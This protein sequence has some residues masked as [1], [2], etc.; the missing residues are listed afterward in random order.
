MS[1]VHGGT[2]PRRL[3]GLGAIATSLAGWSFFHGDTGLSGVARAADPQPTIFDENWQ[4]PVVR[5]VTPVYFYQETTPPPEVA[6]G[7]T[8]PA[9]MTPNSEPPPAAAKAEGEGQEEPK[10]EMWVLPN[11]FDDGCGRNWFKEHN[12]R[13][14]GNVAQSM[15]FNFQSPSDRFNGPVTWTDRSNEYQLN[16]MWFYLEKAT[17]T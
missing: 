2:L 9:E 8:P 4:A 15:T 12:I 14:G 10:D 11:I 7:E 13:L 17:D 6:P 3:L 5:P 1:K 16:Q